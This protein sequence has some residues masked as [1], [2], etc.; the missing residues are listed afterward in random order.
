MVATSLALPQPGQ[1]GFDLTG[2]LGSAGEV[3]GINNLQQ[4]PDMAKSLGLGGSGGFDWG[5][6]MKNF[7]LGAQGLA[8][9]AGAYNSYNQNKLMEQQYR[10][11]I[12]DRNQNIANYA[13][14]T[15]LNLRNQASMASQMGGAGYGSTQ[16]QQD[17]ENATQV[18]GAPITG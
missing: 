2:N 13:A 14:T 6:A 8:G 11:S 12:A 3:Q 4:N 18:S 16:H 5:G 17:I 1:Y 10:A 15:N 9:L 7:S